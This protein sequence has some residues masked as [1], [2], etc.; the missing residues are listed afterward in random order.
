M[1]HNKIVPSRPK[2]SHDVLGVFN[3]AMQAGSRDSIPPPSEAFVQGLVE[4]HKQM[5]EKRPEVA[6]GELK[7][8]MNYA[9]TTAFVAP[10]FVRGTLQEGAS[11]A[12][13]VPE[14]LP[15][16]IY[17]EF[18]VSEVHPFN[19]GNGRMARLLM[20]AELSRRGACRVIIPTLFHPQYVD[21]KKQ[22]TASNTPEA[23]IQA[24]AKM[25]VWSAQFNYADLT[26]LIVDL[27]SCNALEESPVRFHLL[28]QD[29]S[30]AA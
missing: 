22:L 8:Q 27:K 21:C 25:A 16:A 29:G 15:R 13:T 11:I 23:Y 18:L 7:L 12:M 2:D 26:A 3:L 1:L 14:G 17:Y 9:G 20:N 30:R 5:M 28:N 19:D 10:A 6:P 24:I 4:R